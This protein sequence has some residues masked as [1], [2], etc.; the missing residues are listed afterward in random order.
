MITKIVS[1]FGEIMHPQ[2]LANYE[3]YSSCLFINFIEII[4]NLS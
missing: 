2:Q 1:I 3:D 4:L